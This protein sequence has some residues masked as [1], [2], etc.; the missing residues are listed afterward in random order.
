MECTCGAGPVL[1]RTGGAG[2][3]TRLLLSIVRKSPGGSVSEL[4]FDDRVA[5][6]TGGAR[7]LGRAHARLLASR[8][9]MVVVNDDGSSVN[10]EGSS[11]EP[12]EAVA[13]ESRDQ[14]GVAVAD[15]TSVASA[16]GR[17]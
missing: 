12:A 6:V 9:A 2:H 15:A 14:G 5:I 16:E 13:A 10:G 1:R 3:H 7:G 8:G 4:R 17:A 11:A